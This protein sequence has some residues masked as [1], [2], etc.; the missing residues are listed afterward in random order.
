MSVADFFSRI[1]SNWELKLAIG[2]CVTIGFIAIYV[3]LERHPFFNITQVK[4]TWMDQ[5]IPFLPDAV[6][7]YET[8]W[9]L[10]PLSFWLMRSKEE[11]S[12]YCYGFL[13][14]SIIGFSIF[15]L[16]PT[17]CPRPKDLHAMNGVYAT[18][19]RL[20]N[21]HNAF[22]S[23]HAAL[24]IFS[25]SCCNALCRTDHWRTWTRWV[26]WAWVLGIVA[27]TLLTKQHALIDAVAGVILGF[28]VYVICW[29][30]KKRVSVFPA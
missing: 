17:A 2:F 28:G 15:F 13:M 5:R 8:L 16:Y 18:L 7:L 22:P 1:K 14:I 26:I 10:M 21:D 4:M 19:I 11:L 25:G 6:Y 12:R 24:A 9:L 30:I 27:S 23:L 29:R 20:D 3:L